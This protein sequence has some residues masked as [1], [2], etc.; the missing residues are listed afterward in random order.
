M[1]HSMDRKQFALLSNLATHPAFLS[2]RQLSSLTGYALGSVNAVYRE[3]VR[4]GY[5]SEGAIT[6]LGLKV[7]E[8]YRSH[9]I[10]R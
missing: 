6:P 1:L 8:P 2:Q 10:N 7:L 4:Q 5:L 9:W 3:C